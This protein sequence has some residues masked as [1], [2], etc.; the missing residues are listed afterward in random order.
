LGKGYWATFRISW[1]AVEIEVFDDRYELYVFQDRKTEIAHFEKMPG[2]RV[3][4][5]LLQ[6]LRAVNLASESKSE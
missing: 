3:P 5:E 4:H 2:Q 6:R 1:G